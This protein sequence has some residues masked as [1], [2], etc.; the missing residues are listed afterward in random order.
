M[1]SRLFTL[2]NPAFLKCCFFVRSEGLF[3]P[4]LV[5]GRRRARGSPRSGARL[6]VPP[7]AEVLLAHHHCP[8]DARH[9]RPAP[10]QALLASAQAASLRSLVSSSLTNQGSS[11]AR[12]LHS[13]DIAPL[14]SRRQIAVAALADRT[15]FRVK[16]SRLN[17]TPHRIAVYASCPPSPTTTQHSLSGARYGLPIPVFHRL[18]RASFPGAQAIATVQVARAIGGDQDV[19][20][21]SAAAPKT[22]NSQL[23]L[24]SDARRNTFPGVAPV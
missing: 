9:P 23:T 18:D 16:L 1:P 2:A 22:A 19:S 8:T 24:P 17:R 4:D 14:T 21:G 12:L 15:A 10:G 13:T 7:V 11:L 20:P 6:I 5:S 3:R